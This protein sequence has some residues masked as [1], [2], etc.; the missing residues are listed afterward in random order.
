M[1]ASRALTLV[2]SNSSPDAAERGARD[3]SFGRALLDLALTLGI[4]ILVVI[5]VII[6]VTANL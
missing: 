5:L 4:V 2:T 1:V 6:A 3:P